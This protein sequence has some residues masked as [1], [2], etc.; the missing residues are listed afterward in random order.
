MASSSQDTN[1]DNDDDDNDDDVAVLKDTLDWFE[2]V[3]L[4]LDL[5]PFAMASH[6]RGHVD[7]HVVRRR[8]DGDG[9][10]GGTGGRSSSSKDVNN[11]NNII[12]E[13]VLDECERR[14]H[15]PG[16]TLVVCPDL[17]PHDF[18]RYLDVY[19]ELVGVMQEDRKNLDGVV[20]I[21]PFHPLFEFGD[22]GDEENDEDHE[23][24]DEH[25]EDEDAHPMSSSS[26]PSATAVID[27]YT[28]R[29][30]YPVFHILRE[31]EVSNAVRALGGDASRVWK[32]NVALMRALQ[33]EFGNN[34]GD[35]G[36]SN[37]C[38]NNN[39]NDDIND[40]LRAILRGKVGSL[41]HASS[42][43]SSGNIGYKAIQQRVQR[44]LLRLKGD[45]NT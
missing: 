9:A 29:S 7:V 24:D 20:Q 13:H 14:R 2:H 28:N 4:G 17:F 37:N 40:V 25:E 23:E 35:R 11:N 44:I 27:D 41:D 15:I 5:C 43:G 12:I 21:A 32:R 26:L 33:A 18:R 30:P 3:V 10:A 1:D 38:N 39:D 16:T 42:S 31:E 34:G 36:D 22:G 45:G 8:S 6:V 19:D